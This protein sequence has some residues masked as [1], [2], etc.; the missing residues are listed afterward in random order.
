M[1]TWRTI[2]SNGITAVTFCHHGLL[3]NNIL[4]QFKVVLQTQTLSEFGLVAAVVLH[5]CVHGND[6]SQ[7]LDFSQS[8]SICV[9]I[10][11]FVWLVLFRVISIYRLHTVVFFFWSLVAKFSS[12]NVGISNVLVRNQTKK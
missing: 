1:N 6:H 9:F 7:I 12:Y 8:H 3:K 4:L 11:L 5:S 2:Q 10:C